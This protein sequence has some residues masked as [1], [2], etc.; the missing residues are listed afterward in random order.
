MSGFRHWRVLSCLLALALMSFCA[1][2]LFGHRCARRQFEARRDLDNWNEHVG[3]KFDAV[4]RPDPAQSA[5]IQ[6][7]LDQA[8]RELEAIRRDTIA[9]STNVI[10]R[11][12]ADVD[13]ELTPEQRR[14]FATMKPKPGELTLDVLKVKGKP[15]P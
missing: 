15:N 12:V 11:L 3:R 10:G 5:R 9:R 14:A 1:G 13:Q 6:A 8:V 2:L 7:R 4:V